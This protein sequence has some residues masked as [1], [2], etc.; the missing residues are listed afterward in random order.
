[1]KTFLIALFS[2]TYLSIFGQEVYDFDLEYDG[3]EILSADYTIGSFVLNWNSNAG[4][5]TVT[6]T[7][8]ENKILWQTIEGKGFVGA[9]IGEADIE[10]NRGSFI[11]E[12]H[13]ISVFTSQS[14]ESMTTNGDT[15]LICGQVSNDSLSAEYCLQWYEVSNDQLSFRLEIENPIN[16]AYLTYQM[17][18]AIGIF[19]FGAQCSHFNHKGNR[20]P[21]LVQEQGVGRGDVDNVLVDLALG[22]AQGNDYTAYISVPQY[23]TSNS[24]GLFLENYEISNFDFT[25]QDIAQIELY[26]HS[27]RGRIINGDSPVKI[28]EEYTSYSGRMKKLPD[29][30]I[31]GAIIG[32]QGGTSKLYNIWNQLQMEETPLAAFWIQ[33]WVGQR[34]SLVGKQL[35]WNWELDNNRYPEYDL[36]LDS[37]TNNDIQLMG[38]INP[39]LVNVYQQKPYRRNQFQEGNDFGYLVKRENGFPYL[40]PN[41][42]FSS[43]II[44]LSNPETRIWIK[45]IIKDEII[46]R[47]FKGWMADFGEALPFDAVL[48]DEDPAT[49][50]NAYAED[51]ASINKEAVT[52]LDL[53]DEI[54]FFSRSGYT[55]SSG[56][57]TLFWLGDQ[58]VDWGEN[59]GIKSAVTGLLSSGMSGFS[60]MHTDIGGY[61]SFNV[62]IGPVITRSKELLERW[63]QMNAFTVVFRTHEGLGPTANYQIYEDE[64]SIAHFAKWAKVFNAWFFYRKQLVEEAANTGIPV[65]R[66][67]FLHYPDDPNVWD[68]TYQQFML[69]DQFMIAPVTEEGATSTAIYLPSG[70]W[71]NLWT[72]E[73]L[74]SNG[75]TY[76]IDDLADRPAVFYVKGSTVA[77][78]F[79]Q[80]MVD[81]GVYE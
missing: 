25:H 71:I 27:M 38:Y 80:N 56:E 31:E 36:L 62:G 22:S 59:D 7:D 68:L 72:G 34:T 75:Q 30:V 45:D 33:D 32:M 69:G 35:W 57:S 60:Y 6:H 74:N 26:G 13:K 4:Q 24:N 28:L 18:D 64:T 48:N 58:L 42:S 5:L 14:I 47:G 55:K 16:R 46:A 20:V 44:D 40:I 52:E 41:T 77:A 23:I 79:I 61:T 54:V 65:V 1:M 3:N 51:W 70:D 39:F 19:G 76:S 2:I 53:E 15:L 21:V 11:V 66:P 12:D 81:A 78:E 37:L 8:D 63:T 9:A 73:E 43:A 17:D 67:P 49:Y 50:H 10:D 29:W